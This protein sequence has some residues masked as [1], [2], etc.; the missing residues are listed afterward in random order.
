MHIMSIF[1]KSWVH[2]LIL[3]VFFFLAK[4]LF[5]PKTLPVVGPV[6]QERIAVL[7]NQ[8]QADSGRLPNAE[9]KSFLIAAEL[10]QEIMFLRAL[11]DGLHLRDTFV[12]NRLLS[13]MSFLE[14]G[15][16]QPDDAIF[17]QALEMQ[18][19]LTDELIRRRLVQQLERQILAKNPPSEPTHEE[20]LTDFLSQKVKFQEPSR[21]S[22]RHIYFPNERVSEKSDFASSV[23]LSGVSFDDVREVGYPFLSGSQFIDH[24]PE[25]LSRQ[26]DDTFVSQLISES[27]QDNTWVSPITSSLG[28]H[29]VWIDRFTEGRYLTFDDAYKDLLAQAKSRRQ[30]EALESSLQ[31]LRNQYDMRL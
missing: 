7:I 22:I 21:Y 24:S 1:K 5:F 13:S 12:Y 11:E 16:D 10:D 30:G 15:S 20:L 29:F 31:K 9:Q 18:L 14:M 4:Q 28:D 25:Q 2:F 19:H 23:D 17:N 8:W 27:L 6:S 26:F 3:G